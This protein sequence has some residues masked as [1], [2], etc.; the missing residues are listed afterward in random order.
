MKQKKKLVQKIIQNVMKLDKNVNKIT[1]S[2]LV[3]ID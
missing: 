1:S 3:M 2:T